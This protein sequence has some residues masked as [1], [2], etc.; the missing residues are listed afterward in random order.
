[1]LAM[2]DQDACTTQNGH[3]H[4]R[5]GAAQSKTAQQHD[6]MTFVAYLL[7]SIDNA[8]GNHITLH[9]ASKDVDQKGLHLLVRCQ[10][11][12]SLNHL[13][14]FNPYIGFAG[15]FNNL[16]RYFSVCSCCSVISDRKQ[17]TANELLLPSVMLVGGNAECSCITRLSHS[18]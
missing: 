15:Q 14:P 16:C 12:E 6:V 7:C 5:C 11:L 9:D 17:A 1:M 8:L 13:Q 2:M 4:H 18:S 10:Q 3:A